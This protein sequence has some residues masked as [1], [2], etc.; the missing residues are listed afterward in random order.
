MKSN[1]TSTLRTL[2]RRALRIIPPLIALGVV[3]WLVRSR[4]GP[5]EVEPQEEARPMRVVEAPAVDLIPRVI[6]YGLV[7][8]ANTWRAVA[9]VKGTVVSVDP[10]LQAGQLIAQGTRLLQINPADYELAVARLQAGIAEAEARMEELDAE[11]ANMAASLEI[12]QSSLTLAETSLERLRELLAQEA[13]PQD[14]IDREQ[15]QVLKQRLAI[16]QLENAI[17]LIPARRKALE[18]GIAALDVQLRQAQLDLDRTVI[19]APFDCRLGAVR[20]EKGQFLIAGQVLFEAFGTDAVEVEGKFRPEQLQSLLSEEKRIRLT[21]D[22]SM[23]LLQE[24]FDLTV[25]VRLRNA[26]WEAVWP[27]RF[28]RLRESVDPRTRTISVVLRI[29]DPYTAIIPGIRPALVP[30]MY[31]SIELQAPPRPATV[32]VPRTA[33]HGDHLFVLDAEQRLRRR[34]VVPTLFQDDFAAIG[35]GLEPGTVVIVSDPTPAIEGMKIE[36]I[37]DAELISRIRRQAEGEAEVRP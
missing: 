17:A 3:V 23:E 6:G 11:T 21:A 32:I 30:G 8:A 2:L 12:E 4:T 37:T 10:R 26:D 36:A 35:E 9:E 24:L 5:V 31:C 19:E 15:R 13:I 25:M 22:L 28:D 27:A 14:Q 20:I 18:A 34:P 33:V 29:D 16:R 7:D 1:L